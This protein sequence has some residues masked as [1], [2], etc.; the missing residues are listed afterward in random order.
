MTRIRSYSMFRRGLYTLLFGLLLL[1]IMA[2]GILGREHEKILLEEIRLQA[3]DTA[4]MLTNNA[5]VLLDSV[6]GMASTLASDNPQINAVMFQ[7]VKNPI[8]NYFGLLQMRALKTAHSCV[9]FVAIYNQRLDLLCPTDAMDQQTKDTLC[10]LAVSNYPSFSRSGGTLVRMS[11]KLSA[12]SQLTKDTLVFIYYS[13]ISREGHIGSLIFGVDCSFLQ[14]YLSTGPESDNAVIMLI[15]KSGC[16]IS[17]PQQELIGTNLSQEPYVKAAFGSGLDH[18]SAAL[19]IGRDNTLVTWKSSEYGW[20]YI[21]LLPYAAISRRMSFWKNLIAS[22]VI[23]VALFSVLYAY[24]GARHLFM[25]IKKLLGASDYQP[26]TGAQD[27]MEYLTAQLSSY[28]NRLQGER[29]AQEIMLRHW[30]REGSEDEKP[31]CE[32]YLKRHLGNT[33]YALTLLSVDLTETFRMLDDSHRREVLRAFADCVRQPLKGPASGVILSDRVAAIIFAPYPG[34][35]AAQA[36]RSGLEAFHAQ[37]SLPCCA[38][39]LE[40]TS[41]IN[42][43][44]ILYANTSLLL[45]EHFYDPQGSVILH[46]QKQAH[47]R[48]IAYDFRWEMAVWEAIRNKDT[49]EVARAVGQFVGAVRECDYES[50]SL[51]ARQLMCNVIAYYCAATHDAN[52]SALYVKVREIMHLE[53]LELAHSAMCGLFEKLAGDYSPPSDMDASGRIVQQATR[54]TSEN[55]GNPEFTLNDVA[56]A[57]NLSPS[58]FN[59][60]FKKATGQSYSSYLNGF[61]LSMLCSLLS[62]TAIP[63]N[64]LFAEVG[65]ANEK[66]GFTLFKKEY[67]VTPSQYR[68]RFSAAKGDEA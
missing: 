31:L 19:T 51:Y 9:S 22:I 67:G 26:G 20:A 46:T 42:G 2:I 44:P 4:Y 12:T 17:H 27:E 45:Q 23:G 18:G 30:L 3:E 61:R 16:V 32:D 24:F 62:T 39:F 37:F 40:Q 54:I 59:R 64:R 53:T 52:A 56:E 58:Y 5:E 11:R 63:L 33:E 25:P 49:D 68:D 6:L 29:Q 66:Y 34:E 50:V 55:Y 21:S 1:G 13:D 43:L 41:P 7:T 47:T 60:V 65:I 38:A 10:R 14:D 57:L 48:D 36:I 8:V 35:D 28:R 15:D